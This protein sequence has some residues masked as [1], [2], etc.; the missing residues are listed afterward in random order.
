MEFY[1]RN[2]EKQTA[3]ESLEESFQRFKNDINATRDLSVLYKPH[4]QEN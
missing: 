3:A 4:F 2:P 1:Q